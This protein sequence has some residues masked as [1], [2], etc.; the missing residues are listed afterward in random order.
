MPT[1]DA[2]LKLQSVF[3]QYKHDL[4]KSKVALSKLSASMQTEPDIKTHEGSSILLGPIYDEH[5]KLANYVDVSTGVWDPFDHPRNKDGMF[6]RKGTGSFLFGLTKKAFFAKGN[7]VGTYVTQ[8]PPDFKGGIHYDLKPGDTSYGSTHGNAYVKHADGSWTNYLANGKSQ[9][10]PAGGGA[11][12]FF[13]KKVASG[14]FKQ[15]DHQPGI[16][17]AANDISQAENAVKKKVAVGD[18]VDMAQLGILPI[19]TVVSSGPIENIEKKDDGWHLPETGA[20]IKVWKTDVQAKVTKLGTKEMPDDW[21]SDDNGEQGPINP[22]L[23]SKPQPAQPSPTFEKVQKDLDSGKNKDEVFG[24]VVSE[25]KTE[26]DKVDAEQSK[27]PAVGSNLTKKQW[28]AAPDGTQAQVG[29]FELI[30]KDGKWGRVDGKNDHVTWSPEAVLKSKA[31]KPAEKKV[32]KDQAGL[33]EDATPKNVN[34]YGF[35]K[36]YTGI[37]TYLKNAPVGTRLHTEGIPGDTYD[38][39][40][41]ED[42]NWKYPDGSFNYT[43]EEWAKVMVG[44]SSSD[45]NNLNPKESKAT[46]KEKSD[47]DKVLDALKGE[48]P[49]LVA[50]QISGKSVE[51]VKSNKAKKNKLTAQDPND[52]PSL[53]E[54]WTPIEGA[55]GGMFNNVLH[56]VSATKGFIHPVSKDSF[57]LKKGDHLLQHKLTPG[58]F[59]VLGDDGTKKFQINKNGKKYKWSPH[60]PKSNYKVVYT[61]EADSQD[62]PVEEKI[63]DGTQ[64]IKGADFIHPVSGKTAHIEEGETLMQH[65][66]TPNS[67]L[68]LNP[69][70]SMKYKIDVKGNIEK[71]G[72]N[73]KPSNYHSIM[74]GPPPKVAKHIAHDDPTFH[75]LSGDEIMQYLDEVLEEGDYITTEGNKWTKLDDGQFIDDVEGVSISTKSLKHAVKSDPSEGTKSLHDVP[76]NKQELIDW[77]SG[78]ENGSSI[79]SGENFSAKKN[80]STFDVHL[81]D[82]HWPTM[83]HATVATVVKTMDKSTKLNIKHEAPPPPPKPKNNKSGF[84]VNGSTD[85]IVEK[86]HALPVGTKIFAPKFEWEVTKQDDSNWKFPSGDVWASGFFAAMVTAW[87][88]DVKNDVQVDEGAPKTNPQGVPA[89][90]EKALNKWLKA[91]PVG[92]QVGIKT[93][94]AGTSKPPTA[95]KTDADEWTDDGSGKDASTAILAKSIVANKNG[96]ADEFEIKKLPDTPTGAKA[97]ATAAKKVSLPSNIAGTPNPNIVDENTFNAFAKNKVFKELNKGLT[98][99]DA[100]VVNSWYQL[101][102]LHYVNGYDTDSKIKALARDEFGNAISNAIAT[103]EHAKKNAGLAPGTK[104]KATKMVKKLLELHKYHQAAQKLNNGELPEEHPVDSTFVWGNKTTWAFDMD[105][106][107]QALNNSYDQVKFKTESASLGWDPYNGT[108][109]QYKEYLQGTEAKEWA[110]YLEPKSVKQLALHYMKAPHQQMQSYQIE[111]LKKEASKGQ[112]AAQVSDVLKNKNGQTFKPAFITQ[113]KEFPEAPDFLMPSEWDAIKGLLS[114]EIKVDFPESSI[115]SPASLKD[116]YGHLGAI[117]PPEA[118]KALGGYFVNIDGSTARFQKTV[119]YLLKS[120]IWNEDAVTYEDPQFGKVALTPGM[121]V[122]KKG[123]ATLLIPKDFQGG[124]VPYITYSGD[125]SRTYIY[126]GDLSEYDVVYTAPYKVTLKDSQQDG[127]NFSASDW[128]TI[129]SVEDTVAPFESFSGQQLV[130]IKDALGPDSPIKVSELSDK[131]KTLV[132]LYPTYADIIVYKEQKGHYRTDEPQ[133]EDGPTTEWGATLAKAGVPD[134]LKEVIGS[135]EDPDEISN[136]LSDLYNHQLHSVYE[137]L[138][139]HEWEES[140]EYDYVLPEIRDIITAQ[141]ANVI[142]K[143]VEDHDVA[144]FGTLHK[145]PNQNLG[146]MRPKVYYAN[147]DGELYMAKPDNKDKFRVDTEYAAVEIGKLYGF[148]IPDADIREINGD[149]SYVQYVAPADKNLYGVNPSDLEDKQLVDVMSGHALDWAISQHDTHGGQLL[150]QPNGKVLKIDLGQAYKFLG[151]DL[152]EVGYLP[153]GNPEPVWYD[154]F[155]RQIEKGEVDKARLDKITKSVLTKARRI[156]TTKDPLFQQSLELAF[157]RRK[158]WPK[159]HD[160]ESFTAMAMDR[161]HQTF[162][163]FF[164]FY[165]GLYQR[166]GYEFGFT[167]DQFEQTTLAGSKAHLSPTPDFAEQVAFAKAHG[168]S[169]FFASSE[170]EDA[171]A[172]FYAS[173]TAAGTKKTLHG[174]MKIR[175]DGDAE[176]K[177]WISAQGVTD[178][179]PSI[180]QNTMQASAG[181]DSKSSSTLGYLVAYAKTVSVHQEDGQYNPGTVS[182]AKSAQTDLEYK[183]NSIKQGLESDP[184]YRHPDFETGHQQMAWAEWANKITGQFNAVTEAMQTSQ[185]S[186]MVDSSVNYTPP[187]GIEVT[188]DLKPIETVELNG[189]IYTK[190]NDFTVVG[191]I[192]GKPSMQFSVD[193]YELYKSSQNA[194]V[195]DVKTS[196]EVKQVVASPKYVVTKTTF[197]TPKFNGIGDDATLVENGEQSWKPQAYD[198]TSSENPDITLHYF[199]HQTISADNTNQGRLQIHVKEWDGDHTAVDRAMGMLNDMGVDTTPAD[200]TSLELFYWRHLAGILRQ[201]KLDAAAK[202]TKNAMDALEDKL[203]DM[204]AEEEIEERKKVFAGL[205]GKDVVDKAEWRPQIGDIA[206]HMKPADADDD[207]D[208]SAGRPHWVRP[209]F[210]VAQVKKWSN[211]LLPS[212]S[213]GYGSDYLATGA[214][215]SNEEKIRYLGKFGDN[216]GS[217]SPTQDRG[218]GSG[219][220]GFLRQ[221]QSIYNAGIYVEPHVLARTSNYAFNSDEYGNVQTRNK[222]SPFD[223]QGSIAMGQGDSSNELMFKYGLSIWDDVAIIFVDSVSDKNALVAKF[224]AAGITFLRGIAIEERIV[225]TKDEA[226]KVMAKV[227]AQAEKDQANG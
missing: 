180:S 84:P 139:G 33:V 186:P 223:L 38:I 5:V 179:I 162:A 52:A 208:V 201:R 145:L 81:N 221:G 193:E 134:F 77:L 88:D 194:V 74:T 195:K 8:P 100:D 224:K 104:T 227:W 28:D 70:G 14:V 86:L 181:F 152:L 34:Q 80:G 220:F 126:S 138:T 102:M 205:W 204:S 90:D 24:N 130:G 69:D 11:T 127:R 9:D 165:Q 169:L 190:Y 144:K 83:Y 65:N 117:I 46:P 187:E 110:V 37:L 116:R 47:E 219:Q 135:E 141:Q 168:K 113:D 185:K 156:A 170:I 6:V 114:G 129:E 55:E 143:D 58:S 189:V 72:T 217:N 111:G 199:P 174:D 22:N 87:S 107:K 216:Y 151:N 118:A 148:N 93:A 63:P 20:V 57:A 98:G 112:F 121:A 15:I 172:L 43:P 226:A 53:E 212:R 91:L 225:T 166:G 146:G 158:T 183:L 17:I 60:I 61:A 147:A 26:V 164:K 32:T 213:D 50:A 184:F 133:P 3:D 36:D 140:E 137:W 10:F 13:E 149:Y 196:D 85:E 16:E 66:F 27:L 182:A 142:A 92:T 125:L 12:D 128:A 35:P 51:E 131:A 1:Q 56:V 73:L 202:K 4:K 25:I 159:G 123:T 203:K 96:K 71:A 157:A 176:I 124:Y 115:S 197:K 42:G 75:L 82:S 41:H 171:H 62:Q 132:S 136:A 49:D 21:E 48:D 198:I 175:T 97:K 108:D 45:I 103:I 191:S 214:Y 200:E 78:I 160:R 161:K 210:N 94:T 109:D 153:P 105:Y 119:V 101:D 68:V 154:K 211:G 215:V 23:A 99:Q 163:D 155:Y 31:P 209:D 67:Y 44:W 76:L 106:V 120:G 2:V 206:L 173:Q 150:L 177:A 222:K 218:H 7:G 18:T 89:Y 64:F 207:F 29:E 19:G 79:T 40:K 95:T 39:V 59:A 188:K 178:E 30:K 192:N 54:D 167:E 122:A